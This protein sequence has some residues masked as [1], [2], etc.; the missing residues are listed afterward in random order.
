MDLTK[1]REFIVQF[2][3]HGAEVG[4]RDMFE[5]A[6][7]AADFFRRAKVEGL[8]TRFRS[9]DGTYMTYDIETNTIGFYNSNFT[10]KSFYHPDSAIHLHPTNLDYW[11]SLVG[12]EYNWR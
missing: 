11:N 3:K 7:K 2:E 6:Q 9:S 4:A 12:T 10:T 1:I 8:P 5:Y